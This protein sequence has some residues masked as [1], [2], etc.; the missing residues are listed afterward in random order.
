MEITFTVIFAAVIQ[1]VI[2]ILIGAYLHHASKDYPVVDINR[3]Q[4]TERKPEKRRITINADL[5]DENSP[6]DSVGTGT[7][8]TDKIDTGR[9]TRRIPV[10][11]S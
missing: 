10:N 1:I 8:Q 11:Q 3:R 6:G 2:G 9:K 4:A 5:F 7:T